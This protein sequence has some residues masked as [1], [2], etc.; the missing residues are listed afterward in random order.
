MFMKLTNTCDVQTH[1]E[2]L[3]ELHVAISQQERTIMSLT[4]NDQQ[5][6]DATTH[7]C[8]LLGALNELTHSTIAK[9]VA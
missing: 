8:R 6:I 1:S 3:N 5:V 9:R 7:L 2:Q 4:A